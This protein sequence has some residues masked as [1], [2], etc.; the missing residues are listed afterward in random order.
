[1]LDKW[2]RCIRCGEKVEKITDVITDNRAM[3]YSKLRSSG[4]SVDEAT[5]A[6]FGDLSPLAQDALEPLTL[7][8]EPA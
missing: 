8:K 5:K 3:E 1:M 7:S 4:M 6:V 2:R